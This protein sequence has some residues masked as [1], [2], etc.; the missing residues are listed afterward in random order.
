MK[1]IYAKKKEKLS[2]AI[3][4]AMK[5]VSIMLDQ[6]VQKNFQT[7]GLPVGGWEEIARNGMILQ[8]TG[9]LRHSFIPFSTKNNAG[10]GSDLPYSV[11]HEKGIGVAKRRMLPHKKDVIKKARSI[12]KTE[13]TVASK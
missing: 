10:I 7:E 5:K 1:A 9:T 13:L 3:N 6:W 12:I 11:I 4:P 8:D 2:S